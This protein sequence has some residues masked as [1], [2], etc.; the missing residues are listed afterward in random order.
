[1]DVISLKSK[2]RQLIHK[3][4]GFCRGEPTATE[5]KSF[6]EDQR[7]SCAFEARVRGVRTV[8][9]AAIVGSLGRY[10][11]F[12][13]HFRLKDHVPAERL[14]YIR[15]AMRQGRPL[16]PVR[17]CQIKDEYFIE[18]GNHRIAVAKELGHDEI[19]A[20]IVEYIPSGDSFE[21]I[22]YR[23]RAEFCDRTKLPTDINL[24]EPGHYDH[25]LAQIGKH[26][27]YLQETL[28]KPVSCEDAARD[29]HRTIYRP[30]C[31]IIRRGQLLDSFPGRTLADLYAYISLHLWE[32]GESRSY[33]I[34]IGE[35]IPQD[36]EAFRS[37]MNQLAEPD[38]PEMQRKI[39]AFVLMS[40][41]G[42]KEARIMEKLM[43][44]D[45]VEE[46]HSVH[47]DA[48]L[49]VKIQLTRNLLSS[50]AETISHFVH[51]KIRKLHGVNSTKTLIPGQSK[52]KER[53]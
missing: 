31:D 7:E 35:L 51:D 9:L 17:L 6:G 47:G 32:K 46:V 48:D 5:V 1:M 50:D 40:V 45:E 20:H 18:D 11:D 43:E 38:Y 15:E 16:P 29:W 39:T 19:L 2:I 33:G 42:R 28:K 30:L 8:P 12:D 44:Y 26:Q 10:H 49:L 52:I 13:S 4:W 41:Q 21:D 34:G 23:Q 25:L 36:M 3:F 53:F 24:T 14:N 22:L 37:K 27:K